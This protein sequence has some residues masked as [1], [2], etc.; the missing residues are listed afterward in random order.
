MARPWPSEQQRER[1]IEFLTLELRLM[2]SAADGELDESALR[3][4]DRLVSERFPR[5]R[6]FIESRLPDDPARGFS[7]E[8]RAVAWAEARAV[9]EGAEEARVEGEWTEEEIARDINECFSEARARAG[10]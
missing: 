10:V 8:V 9:A 7:D 5:T 3:E 2:R 1:Y 6:T 4:L